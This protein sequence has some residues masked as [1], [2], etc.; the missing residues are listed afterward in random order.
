M[1]LEL[2]TSYLFIYYIYGKEEKAAVAQWIR[3]L[4]TEQEIHGSSPCSGNVEFCCSAAR[5]E[6]VQLY[7]LYFV[8]Q[9]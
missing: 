9:L 3:R 1:I 6:S 4:P 5:F 2:D 7:V 8:F